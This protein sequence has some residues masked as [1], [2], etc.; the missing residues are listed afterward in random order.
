MTKVNAKAEA[1]ARPHAVL[2]EWGEIMTELRK[3]CRFGGTCFRGCGVPGKFCTSDSLTLQLRPRYATSVR[4][5]EAVFRL[6][7]AE[8]LTFLSSVRLEVE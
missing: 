6:A 3:L 7:F 4:R 8:L 5:R 2:I 1:I